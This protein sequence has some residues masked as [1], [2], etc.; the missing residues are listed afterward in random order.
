MKRFYYL[1]GILSILLVSF[2][3]SPFSYATLF[4]PAEN[5]FPDSEINVPSASTS[6]LGESI[7]ISYQVQDK[8]FH[9]CTYY[10]YSPGSSL[11]SISS[12][13]PQML[14]ND[15]NDWDATFASTNAALFDIKI[16]FNIES[17][18]TSLSKVYY[19]FKVDVIGGTPEGFLISLD[20]FSSTGSS[21]DSTGSENTYLTDSMS[22]SS[23][24]VV[25]G[26]IHGD[27][28]IYSPDNEAQ[29]D[30]VI[31]YVD[32]LAFEYDAVTETRRSS[33]SLQGGTVF[34][35]IDWFTWDYNVETTLSVPS[36]WAFQDVNP[37]CAESSD[38]FSC[39]VPT[40]YTAIYTSDV[41]ATANWQE[42]WSDSFESGWQQ[43]DLAINAP[44]S[45][46]LEY[47]L[48]ADGSTSLQVKADANEGPVLTERGSLYDECWIVFSS[49]LYNGSMKITVY[50]S[51]S[52]STTSWSTPKGK[53]FTQLIHVSDLQDSG[54][55]QNCVKIQPVSGNTLYYL[56]SFA[57][58]NSSVSAEK[59]ITGTL[60]HIHP[61]GYISASYIT[62]ELGLWDASYAWKE[63]QTVTTSSDGIW[64]FDTDDF[65]TSLSTQSYHLWTWAYYDAN[66]KWDCDEN[67]E[68][69]SDWSALGG[70]DHTISVDGDA[71]EGLYSVEGEYTAGSSTMRTRYDPG[72]LFAGADGIFTAYVNVNDTT[73]L[74]TIGWKIEQTATK[75]AQ[76][77]F[78]SNYGFA[79]ATWIQTSIP[80]DSNYWD[81]HS[82]DDWTSLNYIQ[83]IA[84]NTTT[85]LG[86]SFKADSLNFIDDYTSDTLTY[87]FSLPSDWDLSGDFDSSD[88]YGHLRL[89]T[90]YAC[91]YVIYENDS[92]VGTGSA[93]TGS[94]NNIRWSLNNQKGIHIDVGVKFTITSYTG[95]QWL[96]WSYDN[97]AD[98]A[99][100]ISE[101]AFQQDDWY[102]H[103]TVYTNWANTSVTIIDSYYD[104][105]QWLNTTK[106]SGVAEG[107]FDY[108][109]NQESGNHTIYVELDGGADSISKTVDYRWLRDYPDYEY[110]QELG[111]SL[112]EKGMLGLGV[113][114]MLILLV[115]LIRRT[116]MPTVYTPPEG[117]QRRVSTPE[118]DY[119][120][121]AS[122]ADEPA[123]QRVWEEY[124]I[125]CRENNK[126]VT[127]TREQV[128]KDYQE[129]KRR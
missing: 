107:T 27:F 99:L 109:V 1:L 125:E 8:I 19:D 30:A 46:A 79:D 101:W 38:V 70:T 56:D 53:W 40:T 123:K 106:Y 26:Y 104:G 103:I 17:P 34:N 24:Y 95:Q 85:S 71:K 6:G 32:Q 113:L 60:R 2:P 77:D 75:Y 110:P 20:I 72:A 83:I 61:N 80:T 57:I 21:W 86:Y 91:S 64:S 47:S 105:V 78:S 126:P 93:V 31:L 42:V 96:N 84:Y 90:N 36:S 25:D 55:N 48:V 28:Y 62:V 59:T 127:K 116:K 68:S 13:Y 5:P 115:W 10:D 124:L 3:I 39:L 65:S 76:E 29:Q 114:L 58:Y 89:S 98:A 119:D 100:E 108:D 111:L 9:D 97:S 18:Y 16:S 102:I 44:D 128:W 12:A 73:N 52:W 87:P 33:Y 11:V 37:D 7:D 45:Y 4:H 54:S 118:E 15:G 121:L 35:T 82:I 122:D 88:V 94:V 43:W 120:R 14:S 112:L 22:L 63:Y 74:T 50:D 129:G 49:Y 92:S 23:N 81:A 66:G 51:G 117:E 69:S 67:T 41:M